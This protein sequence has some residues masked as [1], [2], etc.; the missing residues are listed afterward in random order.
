M[1]FDAHAKL[2]EIAGAPPATSA[3]GTPA[4]R[5][6]SQKSQLSQAPTAEKAAPRVAIVASVATPPKPKSEPAPVRADGLTPDA[7]AFL[8][9][10][11]E[12]GPQSYDAV[13]RAFGWGATRAWRAE[14]E[15]RAVGFVSYQQGRA[16]LNESK[17]K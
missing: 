7:G 8:D 10:L 6:L 5:A 3:L 16:T 12:H 11:R 17:K 14:A 9:F 15:L 2:A 13:A 1:W 4:R